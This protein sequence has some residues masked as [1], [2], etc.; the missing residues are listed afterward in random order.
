ML[1]DII[2]LLGIANPQLSLTW[3]DTGTLTEDPALPMRLSGTPSK[4]W[5][6]PASGIFNK[7]FAS[8]LTMP[9][10]FAPA[11]DTWV[12][13]IDPQVFLRLSR[14]YG[15]FLEGRTVNTDK[16]QRP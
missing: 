15:L 1:Q 2:S 4:E 12:L 11:A 5:L 8:R 13:S 3:Q 10:G 7:D 9:N 16:P 6:A 14:I